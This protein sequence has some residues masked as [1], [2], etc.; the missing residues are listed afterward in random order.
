MMS[1]VAGLSHRDIPEIKLSDD[2][3][4]KGVEGMFQYFRDNRERLGECASELAM[5]FLK[6]SNGEYR[7]FTK[8]IQGLNADMLSFDN[9]YYIKAS[10]MFD[11]SEALEILDENSEY[12]S[13]EHI[14]GF[15]DAFCES[16][17]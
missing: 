9:P 15:V 12:I 11:K 6:N 5:L 10:I 2:Q 17:K 4:A 13:T 16:F 8:A 1:F 3:Y 14:D 7:Q